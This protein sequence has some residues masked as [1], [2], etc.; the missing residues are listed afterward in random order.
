M[1]NET[2]FLLTAAVSFF[3]TLGLTFLYES[4]PR[5]MGVFRAGVICKNISGRTR[6]INDVN[7]YSPNRDSI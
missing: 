1:N 4:N 7:A 6:S 5:F 3:T 2:G